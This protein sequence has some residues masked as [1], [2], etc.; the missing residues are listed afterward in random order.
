MSTGENKGDY[1]APSEDTVSKIFNKLDT[2]GND[3]GVMR[4]DVR[5][6]KEELKHKAGA[7]E[8]RDFVELK[9][10]EHKDEGRGEPSGILEMPPRA[11]VAGPSSPTSKDSGTI[12]ISLSGAPE[13]LRKVIFYAVAAGGGGG[14][15]HLLH[16][17]L[18]N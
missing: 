8:M 14:I 1:M 13:A 16:Q 6:I 9:I 18:L 7:V 4:G 17:W 10:R 3:V 2:L 15:V 12:R 11:H 5:V